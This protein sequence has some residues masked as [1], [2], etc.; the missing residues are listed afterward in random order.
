MEEIKELLLCDGKFDATEQALYH[1]FKK[2]SRLSPKYKKTSL[3]NISLQTQQSSIFKLIN[4]HLATNHAFNLKNINK[5]PYSG[6]LE[7]R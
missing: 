5:F 1:Y 6:K 2:Y 7:N 4:Q 3:S